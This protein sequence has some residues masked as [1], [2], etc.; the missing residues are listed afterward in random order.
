MSN[1][2]DLDSTFGT[3]GKVITTLGTSSDIVTSVVIDSSNKIVVAGYTTKNTGTEFAVARYNTDGSLDSTFGTGGKVSTD[4]AGSSYSIAYSVAIDSNNKIVVAGLTNN[5]GI[6]SFAITRY[7]G[8]TPIIPVAPICFPAGTP[9]TTDQGIIQIEKINILKH[10][11]NKHR[12]VAITQTVQEGKYI[13]CI[14]KNALGNNVPSNTTYISCCHK[15]LYKGKM[16]ESYKLVG[17]VSGVYYEYYN[18]EILYNV[19]LEK[20]GIMKV[21]N[22]VAETLHPN[23]IIA[24]LY[25]CKEYIISEKE[26]EYLVK[27]VNNL[28]KNRITKR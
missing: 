7:I 20:H 14:K 12:I 26:Y 19:L 24:K 1:P 28:V 27:I 6:D 5:G 25:S 22:L 2:G 3:G 17:K 23:N 21:N 15:I 16:V 4:F 13:V 9:I 10:T 8:S 18:N 11:I